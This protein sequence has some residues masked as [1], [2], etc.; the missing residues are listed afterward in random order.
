[1]T[2][3]PR[4]RFVRILALALALLSV[5]FASVSFS[6]TTNFPVNDYVTIK[7]KD[8]SVLE[9]PVLLEDDRQ[10][11]IE[12]QYAN[13]TISRKDQV[14]KNDIASISH[15][16]AVDRDQRLATIAYHDLGKYQLDPQ[17]S[18][19]LSYYDNA[20]S[21]GFLP[22]LQ[23]Y[24]H[25]M[26]TAI[27]SNRLAE[28][29]AERSQVASGQVKYH[30]QW[31]TAAEANKLAETERTQQVVQDAR[32]LIAQGQFDAA[33]EK[34]APYYNA[35]QPSPLVV[36][37]RRLQV[38]VYRLWISSLE[39]AQGQ[40]TKDL[41]ATKERVTRLAEIR[42]RAQANY[43]SARGKSM[44]TGTRA[45]GDSA[46]SGQASADYLRAEKQYNE[47]QNRQFAIQ[48][49]LD[50]TIRQLRQVHQNQDLFTAAYPAIEV[51][52]EMPLPPP[53]TNVPAPAPPPE[54]NAPAPPP[55]PP[56]PPTILDQT[57]AWFSRNWIIIAGVGLLGLWGVSRLFTRP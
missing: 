37:S 51:V 6:Q 27:I 23:Q 1:M 45:L 14:D 21:Q 46:I 35:A 24:P 38:D 55:P 44:V 20:I 15:L 29:Q 32:A 50:N 3:I 9:G 4:C 16:S 40:L 47:E 36:E 5:R 11:T 18:L 28:W 2:P 48:E 22:F 41:E 26:E 52:K 33:T 17:S 34:L 10:I 8:G 43:D 12:A 53:K 54:T 30:G 25:V 57:G 7:L 56:P 13:G 39:T 19:Q 42:S 49:Q 31:M